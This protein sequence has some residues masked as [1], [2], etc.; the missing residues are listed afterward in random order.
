MDEVFSAKTAA[1]LAGFDS[2][3]ML[4]Y[5][6]RAEVF[7]R[8]EVRGW[9]DKRRHG[10]RRFYTFR[11]IIILRSIA[12]LLKKGVGVQR[13]K[14]A[15]LSFSKDEKFYC[16]RNRVSYGSE[17]IQYFVTDGKDI[18]FSNGGDHLTSLL[19]QGQGTFSFVLDLAS[20]ISE[21][22]IPATQSLGRRGR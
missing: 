3:M 1:Y 19:K 10:R 7:E 2:R 4:D 13:I 21:S 11:D 12:N 18:Y 14:D 5:L 6:E 8:E 15:I 22:P 20:T 16:D 17:P 9:K